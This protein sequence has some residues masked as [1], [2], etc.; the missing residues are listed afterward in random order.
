MLGQFYK[1]LIWKVSPIHKK[2]TI[3]DYVNFTDRNYMIHHRKILREDENRF[4][5]LKEEIV[6]VRGIRDV[7]VF[8]VK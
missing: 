2:V 6:I 3:K 7:G 8:H 4:Q 5:V 1:L